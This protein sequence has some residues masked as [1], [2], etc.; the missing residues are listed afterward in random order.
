MSF[1]QGSALFVYICQYT[2]GVH[3]DPEILKGS[4]SYIWEIN[5]FFLL[6]GNRKLSQIKESHSK[7][8]LPLLVLRG[9]TVHYKKPICQKL[10]AMSDSLV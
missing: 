10:E 7:K 1:V 5:F 3:F 8:K 9:L 6:S 4:K 2:F